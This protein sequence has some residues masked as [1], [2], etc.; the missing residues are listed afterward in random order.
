MLRLLL[1]LLAP[2]KKPSFNSQSAS[3]KKP[4]GAPPIPTVKTTP[5]P[6][7]PTVM[8]VADGASSSNGAK[9]AVN[10][11]NKQQ[12]PTGHTMKPTSFN[13]QTKHSPSLSFAWLAYAVA[14]ITVGYGYLVLFSWV[15]YE[16]AFYNEM[17]K[18]PVSQLSPFLPSEIQQSSAS[19]FVVAKLLSFY[20]SYPTVLIA[21]YLVYAY[22][23]SGIHWFGSIA[24]KAPYHVPNKRMQNTAFFADIAPVF[25]VMSSFWA[26]M[27]KGSES[28]EYIRW[29]MCGP[30]FLGMLCLAAAL[31][32]VHFFPHSEG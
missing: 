21:G 4:S 14:L 7:K 29:V 12:S 18:L 13:N 3:T 32:F 27:N 22:I 5:A 28:S 10:Y 9:Q 15:S 6:A 11:H 31:I 16:S 1:S 23:V 26:L 2:N 30:S 19:R 24:A 17:F 8:P 20:F 25:G